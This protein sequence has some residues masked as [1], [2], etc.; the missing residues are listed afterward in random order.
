MMLD[1]EQTYICDLARAW[2]ERVD[3]TV[4]SQGPLDAARLTRL[5][6]SQP[7]MQTL[8]PY[9]DSAMLT[10]KG[11]RRVAAALQSSRYR[12]TMML[13]EL[14]RILPSLADA[15]CRPVVLKGASLALTVYDRPE[16]RWFVDLDLMVEP[17]QL[18]RTYAA[19]QEL[20]YDFH[21][22]QLPASYY[23]AYHFHRI[24]TNTWGICL[25]VHWA[26]T[27]PG[28]VY[29]YDLDAMRADVSEVVLGD[30]F[31][32][33]PSALDQ[34][35]HGVLQSIAGGFRD[36]RRILDLQ[37]LDAVLPPVDHE[38]LCDR[39][40]AGNFATALWLQYHVRDQLL[41]IPIPAVIEQRC[42]PTSN[43]VSVL[44][45]LGV[46][47]GCLGPVGT[48]PEEYPRLLHWL[49]I[50]PRDRRQ[51]IRRFILPGE[52]EMLEVGLGF[53]R[54]V[55]PWRRFVLCADRFW[56]AG[57]M[58]GRVARASV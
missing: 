43:V 34:I 33:A 50:P 17:E 24:M 25:E 30:S 46:A 7:A 35:L 38:R 45:K 12:T 41:G 1:A 48:V 14:E 51:E 23:E 2:A 28:S 42:R 16:D 57:R 4:P 52:A 37:R 44:D 19:L 49:C 39:A 29:R 47:Q 32:L 26:V 53:D 8:M 55:R 40:R 21:E 13:L 22:T 18:E 58:L 36:L 27:R 10:E 3:G 20:G 54:P 6:E 31:F 5:L 11:C 9:L 15:G 56:A